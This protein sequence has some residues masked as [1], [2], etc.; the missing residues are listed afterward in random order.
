MRPAACKPLCF[1]VELWDCG[2]VGLWDCGSASY[3]RLGLVWR[4]G[5]FRARVALPQKPPHQQCE[6]KHSCGSASYARL[7]FGVAGWFVSRKS[8]APT[9][10]VSTPTAEPI[11]KTCFC[12]SPFGATCQ[13]EGRPTWTTTN[14]ARVALP[15]KPPHQQYELKHSC[16]SASYAR[17][18]LVWRDG[19]FRARVAPLQ[20]L[21]QATGCVKTALLWD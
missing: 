19:L 5:L 15:Q 8:C 17:L 3:A 7:R 16:G 4:D 2:T 1:T 10:A 11:H 21:C 6:L 20:E 12:R 13:P 9:T 14:R 18:G